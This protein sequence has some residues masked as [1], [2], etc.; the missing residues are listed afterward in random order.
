MWSF[1]PCPAG[2]GA[3]GVVL[4]AAVT[5]AV[6]AVVVFPAACCCSYFCVGGG[7]ASRISPQTSTE[8]TS[9]CL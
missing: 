3:L 8:R 1:G 4:D 6:V 9:F 2:R 5:V 7:C